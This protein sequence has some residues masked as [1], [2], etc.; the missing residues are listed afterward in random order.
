MKT[1]AS[2]SLTDYLLD[3]EETGLTVAFYHASWARFPMFAGLRRIALDAFIPW[4]Q[5]EAAAYS[6]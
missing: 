2:H 6:R 5:G 3:E 4:T 1:R